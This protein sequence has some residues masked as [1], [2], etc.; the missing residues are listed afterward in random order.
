MP[1]E[2]KRVSELV[3]WCPL[4]PSYEIQ[5]QGQPTFKPTRRPSTLSPDEGTV[6]KSTSATVAIMTTADFVTVSSA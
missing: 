5:L 1:P 2:K 4:G 3:L 6:H